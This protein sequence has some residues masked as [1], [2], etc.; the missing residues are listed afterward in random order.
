MLIYIT[1]Y[2]VVFDNLINTVKGLNIDTL[3]ITNP[4]DLI[5]SVLPSLISIWIGLIFYK[6]KK[7]M[8]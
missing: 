8:I 6:T 1:V 5:V 7:D 2:Q 3:S 4:S